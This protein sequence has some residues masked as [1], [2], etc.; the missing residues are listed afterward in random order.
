V[1]R[2]LWKWLAP[3]AGL[4]GLALALSFYF[5]AP[6]PHSYSLSITAGNELGVRHRLAEQL[7]G[8]VVAR[9]MTLDLHPSGGSEQALDWVNSRTM[10]VALV[11][12]SLSPAGRPNVRQV[13]ALHVEPIH[14]L[15]KPGFYREVSAN[16]L[17]LRGKT[18]DLEE[19][20]SGSHSLAKAILQFAGL[21]SRDRDPARG[22]VE[23]STPRQQ[24]FSETD[25]ARL[26]D[27]VF[28]VS[29]LP[30][31][32]SAYLV[33]R[34]GYRLVLMPFAEAF[35]LGSLVKRTADEQPRAGEGRVVLGR[36]QAATI[37]A[38]TYSLEPPVPE[39]P[40][41]TLGTRLL[42]VAHKDVPPRAVYELVE[43]VYASEFGQIVRPPLD[44][45]LMDLPPEFPWHEGTL[46]YQRR[47]APLLSGAV[48]DSARNGVAIFAAA[49]SGLFVLWQW[50]KMY[51][52]F[53]RHK[54][55][56]KYIA[57]VTRIESRALELER[58]RPPAVAELRAL[59]EELAQLKTKALGEFARGE[60]VGKEVLAGFLV[61]VHDVRDHLTRLI[62]QEAAT[63]EEPLR[64]GSIAQAE[65]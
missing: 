65:G 41:P 35:A 26:P 28:L 10:D 2:V 17:A 19:A 58:A 42:L 47:N 1:V 38:F 52:Q 3:L 24:L 16:L 21:E 7:R 51:G 40:L 57:E 49:A 55:F 36:V 31:S 25:P 60:L 15:V 48:M 13:A 34:H 6:G 27:A 32:T 43:A 53:S 33:T 50:L 45:K 11:Q 30:S 4:A 56:H 23:V 62:R 61:Q 39:Q 44:P 63:P 18:V 46:L 64:T 29:T 5:H 20:G 14:L 54:G 37:P 12:G 9:H 59:Q 8:E 22:Y